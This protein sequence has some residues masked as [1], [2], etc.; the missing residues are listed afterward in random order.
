VDVFL[1]YWQCYSKERSL[2]KTQLLNRLLR[3]LERKPED[4]RRLTRTD[5]DVLGWGILVIE[6]L[7]KALAT[8]L[9]FQYFYL[10][11]SFLSYFPF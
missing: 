3:K 11:A 8:R 7:N 4:V 2:Q 9:T 1:H 10:V 6:G 5:D